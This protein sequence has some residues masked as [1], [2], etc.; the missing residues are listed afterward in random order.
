MLKLCPLFLDG[1][2]LYVQIIA[3]LYC[4]QHHHFITNLKP[5]LGAYWEIYTNRLHGLYL[6]HHV[7]TLITAGSGPEHAWDKILHSPRLGHSLR[8]RLPVYLGHYAQKVP[9]ILHNAQWFL[10]PIIP[11]IMPT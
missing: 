5:D 10:V 1:A 6:N 3:L 2:N 8:I 4:V 7:R 9:I 11:K